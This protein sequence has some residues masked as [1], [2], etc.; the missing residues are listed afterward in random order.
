M[1]QKSAGY[2]KAIVL[3]A[4]GIV[5][6]ACSPGS[7]GG[8]PPGPADAM[9]TPPGDGGI[10]CG[11]GNTMAAI[12]QKLFKGPKCLVCHQKLTLFPTRLDLA[13]DGLADRM[14]DKLADPDNPL[15]G[16]CAG[17]VLLPHDDPTGSLF[18]QKVEA[19]PPCGDRMPQGMFPLSADEI[20]CVKLWAT[21]AVQAAHRN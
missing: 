16:K 15:F 11:L 3:L 7:S 5:S 4:V 10:A 18:V 19:N 21:L 14:V 8:A 13:S 20:S 2:T 6:T 1:K 12:E 9:T 17:K